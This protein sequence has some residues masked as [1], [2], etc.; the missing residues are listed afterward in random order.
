MLFFKKL[1]Y[2][3]SSMNLIPLYLKTFIMLKGVPTFIF[4]NRINKIK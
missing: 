1:K 2:K 4:P 3:V